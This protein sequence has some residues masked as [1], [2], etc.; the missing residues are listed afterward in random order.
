M[1]RRA[2]DIPAQ[3]L[4]AALAAYFRAT[5]VQLLYDSAITAGRRSAAVRGHLTAREALAR[6]VAPAGIAVGYTDGDA[7]ILTLVP[8]DTRAPVPL[9]RVVVRDAV[10]APAASPLDRLVYYRRLEE[11]LTAWLGSDPRTGQLAF[12]ATVAI[13]INAAGRISEVQVAR[14][15]GSARTDRLL[16]QVLAQAAVEG[17]PAG[18]AQPLLVTVRGERRD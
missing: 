9:G 18:V 15:T 12:A 1:P 11:Q 16:A 10:R 2:F 13:R 8:A 3:P 14:G 17:P 7:A 4:D 5:G 6:L